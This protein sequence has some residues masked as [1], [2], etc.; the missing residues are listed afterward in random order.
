MRLHLSGDTRLLTTAQ[1]EQPLALLDAALLAWLALEGPTPRARL[2][3][4]LW[5]QK[6]AMSAR[7]SLRQRLFQLRKSLGAEVLAGSANVALAS[8]V[9]HDLD[10]ADTILGETAADDIAPGE[11]AQWLELQR[12]RRRVRLRQSLGELA[13][14]AEAAGDWD[15]ALAHARELLALEPLSE[16]AHRRMI[17]IHYLAGDRAAALLAFDHCEQRLKHEVGARPSAETMSLLSTL[18]AAAARTAPMATA[19]RLPMSVQR[20]PRLVG[21]EDAWA[22]LHDAWDTGRLACVRGEAGMGKTRLVTDFARERGA[23]LVAGARPGD[24]RVVYASATRLLRQVPA[25]A[26]AALDSGVRAEL[27]RLLPELGPSQGITTDAQRT[28]FFNAV[29]ALLDS[30]A[31]GLEGVA[32]DDLHFADDASLELLQF[33]AVQASCRWLFAA[34]GAEL[35][36]AGRQLLAA[37]RGAMLSLDLQPLTLSQV[38]ELLAS[39]SID[40]LD[41]EAAAPALLRHSGGSPLFLLE[42]LKSWLSQG[43]ALDLATRL[44]PVPGVSTLIERRIGQLSIAALRLLRCA[45]VAA[46][47]FGIELASHV[48]GERAIDLADPWAELERAQLLRDGAF[49]HDLIH[50]SALASVPPPVARQLHAEI[51]SF[52]GNSG[53]EPARIAHHWIEAGREPEALAALREAAERAR[54]ALQ[55]RDEIALREQALALAG[56]LGRPEEAFELALS[57]F[58]AQMVV[59]RT[60]IDDALFQRLDRLAAAPTHRLRAQLARADYLM[61][62]GQLAQAAPHAEQAAT[63]ARELGDTVR[64]IEG[65]RCA[66]A[67]A[68]FGGD[69]HRAVD[70]LRPALPRVLEQVA[71]RSDRAAYFADL[72]CCLDNADQPGEALEFHRRALDLVVAARRFDLAA[73]VSANV[74]HNLKATGRVQQAF[75]SAQQA[76]RHAQ[77]LDD[78]RGATYNLDTME[79]ALLRDLARYTQALDAGDVALASMHQNPSRAAVVHGHM[80]WLWM[81]L[82]QHARAWQALDAARAA[83]LPPPLQAR[84]S[85]LQGRLLLALQQPGA[86]AAFERAQAEAPL[87]GRTLVKATVA[88]DHARTLPPAEALAR[89]EQIARQC[90]ALGFDGAALTAHTRAAGFALDA[91]EP[92]CAVA[93]ARLVLAC[94]AD[95]TADDLYPAE[96]WLVA[97]R[98]CAAAGL[99]SE[100]SDAVDAGREWVLQTNETQVPPLYR[101]S[102]LQHNTVNRELLALA[103]QA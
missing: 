94:P 44:P 81:Q 58:E 19:D 7:N 15:D 41:A 91:G 20:P 96:R 78:A 68:S 54:Q 37:P 70:L 27:A 42:T 59:D 57:N 36:E 77:A 82:G 85:Q 32:F 102:F 67:C 51:A 84:V 6:D 71:D 10:D 80:A 13:A 17:R 25:D 87:T 52:L 9:D 86:H 16:L 97:A 63:L 1:H 56:R 12:A 73:V 72:A 23:V 89:C 55:K 100:A 64:E 47:D 5:P 69:S 14:M 74:S 62:T 75:D 93:H 35:S 43:A 48:L 8:G 33:A 34:R 31:L 61:S 92:D 11:F 66:A 28:R 76:R 3:Q 60:H 46:P 49:V 90:S 95:I 101:D 2:A 79:L 29:V 38:S 65:L 45:A 88:L 99:H 39:L 21:R 30:R 26:L 24:Q 98:A 53:G 18:D 50:D 4:L 83:P 40:G 22:A 103:S